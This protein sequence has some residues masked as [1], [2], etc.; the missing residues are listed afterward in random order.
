MFLFDPLELLGGKIPNES[1]FREQG[2][3]VH[4]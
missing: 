4:K 3:L 2:A 1:D